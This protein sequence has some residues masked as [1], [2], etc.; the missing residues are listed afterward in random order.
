MKGIFLVPFNWDN[1]DSHTFLKHK[2]TSA[3]SICLSEAH[4][5]HQDPPRLTSDADPSSWHS[6][7]PRGRE[8]QGCGSFPYSG[9]APSS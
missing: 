6:F 1:Q 9:R 5:S 7:G 3:L 8:S 2:T 4:L